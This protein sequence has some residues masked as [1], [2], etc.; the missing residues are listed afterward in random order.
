MGRW[1]EEGRGNRQ[2][3]DGEKYSRDCT[4]TNK[5]AKGRKWKKERVRN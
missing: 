5:D 3:T 4:H 2:K 1:K